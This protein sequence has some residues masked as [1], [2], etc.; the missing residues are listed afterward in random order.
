VNAPLS[1]SSAD[2][3]VDMSLNDVRINDNC[4]Y[5]VRIAPDAGHVG[6]LALDGATITGSN[7]ALS[8]G[9]GGEGWVSNTRLYL[10]NLGVQPA[11]G[12]IHSYCNNQVAG[13]A[14]DGA[15]TDNLCAGAPTV[16]PPTTTP[17]T[18]PP[19]T[20][21]AT[22][23]CTVP[24]LKKKTA[25]QAAQLLT[26]AGCAL[27]KVKKQAGPKAKKG[28]VLSQDVVAGAEVKL[29]TKVGLVIGR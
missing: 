18:T 13:N 7:V 15:F 21:A 17:P 2:V 11:G 14:S 10:N 9:A 28:T 23:Y 6:R 5:G 25:A 4:Q 22:A 16:T 19:T 12:K 8:V 27:G 3:F 1:G 24:K 20:P 29:A 26:A